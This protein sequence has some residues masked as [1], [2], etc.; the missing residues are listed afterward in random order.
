MATAKGRRIKSPWKRD[1]RVDGDIDH[2]DLDLGD[3]DIPFQ[4]ESHDIEALKLGA[5]PPEYGPEIIGREVRPRAFPQKSFLPF[6]LEKRRYL[7]AEGGAG[8][9]KTLKKGTLVVK[10]NGEL[11][12]VEDIKIGDQVMGP[13]SN[14]RNV[15]ET[16]SGYGPLYKVHQTRGMDYVVND[17]HTLTLKKA[18][19]STKDKGKLYDSGNYKRPRGVYPDEPDIV[20]IPLPEY[21]EKGKKWKR[22]FYGFSV[23]VDFPKNTEP[24]VDP[25]FLGLWLGDGHS[26]STTITTA[27]DEI[28]EF[29]FNFA[30]EWLLKTTIIRKKGTSA[31][32]YHL[33]NGNK[34]GVATVLLHAFQHYNL[35]NNKHIPDDFLYGS[36]KTRLALLAGLIDTDGS[37]S[38][39]GFDFIQK[40]EQL[41]KQ[42]RYICHSLGLRCSCRKVKKTIKSI[43][44]EGLYW[45]LHITG[46]VNMIPTKIARK[47]A[48][49][50]SHQFGSTEGATSIKVEPDGEGEWVGFQLDGDGRYLLEDFTVTHNS[51]AAAQKVIM[52][53]LKYPN[54]MTIV[55]R[56]WSPRLRVTA[57]RMLIQIL[58]ENLIPYHPNN[59]TMKI[60]FENGSVIQGMAI[61]DSQGG[62]VAASIKSLTDISGMWIE[63]PT[64]LSLE[65]FEMIRMRLRGRELPEGQSRQLILTFNPI[66]RNHWLH[67]LFFD[68]QDQPFEDEDTSVR[69]Y[70]YKDNEFIDEAYKKSLENIKDKNRFKV[71]T[72]GLWGELGAMVYENWEPWG[73][74]PRETKFDTI[75]GGADFG[76]SHPSAFCVMGIDDE[77]HDLYVIDEVYQR[78]ELNRDFIDSIKSKLNANG[79]AENI[80]IYCDSANPA[81]IKEMQIG[82]LNA[83]P[84]QKN[85]LDGI[86]AVRQYSI[87]IHT[88]CDHFL[89]EIG[90]YQ[91]A[92]DQAGRV[93]ELPNKKAGF[94]DLMD[95]M[96]YG[97]Y[98]FSLT[99]RLYKS[100]MPGVSYG[101]GPYEY[102]DQL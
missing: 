81:S 54:S 41:A 72:L 102:I 29:L 56:A 48:T 78:E 69:H 96:R 35:L 46:A 1:E 90:G 21:L 15:V 92:K 24:K 33:T 5:E 30:S 44:F 93:M 80:P 99:R 22:H 50:T 4:P 37:I 66:D 27:D 31:R 64:E 83:Q 9:G 86:G 38:H 68:A 49:R 47:Q 45:R 82:G 6:F 79:I 25:Y 12:K 91:R 95:A 32:S 2:I 71:Y 42:V 28:V 8:A 34:G 101:R 59:T 87:K 89:S 40:D 88:Q 94:D 26:N 20:D 53:S 84:A 17:Q 98:T 43:G 77:N 16:H 55:M 63:E 100:I 52:K 13:D 23:G 10:F 18:D 57:Y 75:I 7:V 11:V 76:Y 65:E 60:T 36:R 73:F 3:D 51:V 58:N 74:E 19:F 85:V 14:P 61:V 62:E 97:V 70:T 67:E 39:G